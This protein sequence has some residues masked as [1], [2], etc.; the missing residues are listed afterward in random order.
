MNESESTRPR[1]RKRAALVALILAALT[2]LTVIVVM[3]SRAIR[4]Q[5][6]T[7]VVKDVNGRSVEIPTE[8]RR[9]A[10]PGALNQ[11]VLMLGGADRI[12]ATAT[13][14][15]QNKWFVRAHPAIKDTPAA[16]GI[17]SPVGNV[18]TLLAARPQVLFGTAG[19]HPTQVIPVVEVSLEDAEGIKRTVGVIGEV[20]GGDAVGRAQEYVRY[21]DSVL[22]RVKKVSSGLP[23]DKR[24]RVYT[25]AQRGFLQTDGRRSIA[26]TW[27]EASGGVNVAAATVEAQS[28]PVTME[29][30]LRWDPEVIFT[31]S[32]TDRDRL[33]AEPRWAGISAVK[34]KRVYASPRGVYLWA[35]RSGEGVL[36]YLW[37]AKTLYPAEHANIDLVEET[38]SFYRRFYGME[39]D[40][41][42]A[43]TILE[44]AD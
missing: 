24:V 12:V 44:P 7:R 34:N 4:P 3:R 27:I 6:A 10:C 39:I 14:V 32:P 26:T 33:L 31:M 25:A 40:A 17:S 16:Y 30:V 29:D 21:Y 35:V 13:V 15:Q 19:Q 42:E 2:A 23:K 38:R 36:Q 1:L 9:V 20:L 11:I 8:V 43:R 41:N 28:A 18:E 5:A 22:D 37:A